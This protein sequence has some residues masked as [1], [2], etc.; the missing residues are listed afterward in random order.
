MVFPG[1]QPHFQT[2]GDL[3]CFGPNVIGATGGSGTRVFARIARRGGMFI[4]NNLND[5]EDSLDIGQYLD[6]WINSFMPYWHSPLQA[7]EHNE[8]INDFNLALERHCRPLASRVPQPWGWK[9]PRSIYLLPLFHSQ[10]P[11][12]KF[13]HVIRDGRD[14]AYSANQN[15]LQKHGHTLLR[16]H[17][18][19]RSQ[20]EQSLMLW[21]R[22]N[23]MMAEYGES[24][25]GA[26]YL[27]LRFEDLCSE[28]HKIIRQIFVFF[29]LSGDPEKI[30]AEEVVPPNSLGRWKAQQNHLRLSRL[31]KDTLQTFGYAIDNNA[32]AS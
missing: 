3:A 24:H 17:E 18:R 21:A 15:Q 20:P 28:P 6:R 30:A 9:D 14:M 32:S 11:R 13:L 16:W 2:K 31:A 26:S 1:T 27:R 12:L 23:H 10:L 19:W 8:M 22:I 7:E 5:S 25:M 29:N 4:G